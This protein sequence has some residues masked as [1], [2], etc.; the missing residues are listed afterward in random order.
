MAALS[1]AFCLLFPALI[2]ILY[3][4][5]RWRVV[6]PAI[7]VEGLGPVEGIRRSW[8][9]TLNYWWRTLGLVALLGV[10]SYVIS[11][12][13]TTVIVFILLYATPTNPVL[14]SA[15]SGAVGTATSLLFLPLELIAITLYY[16]DLRV[17][18]EGF[19]LDAAMRQAYQYGQ[20]GYG[21][22]YPQQ[23][24]APQG[25]GPASGY[26]AYGQP[27]QDQ[28]GQYQYPQGQPQPNPAY[29]PVPGY[30]QQGQ[31]T[32]YPSGYPP[33]QGQQY[34]P[35]YPAQYGYGPA[36]TP[37]PQE[38]VNLG[39]SIQPPQVAPGP[40]TPAS[41]PATEDLAQSASDSGDNTP[42]GNDPLG[43]Y[44]SEEQAQPAEEPRQ[45]GGEESGTIPEK[46]EPEV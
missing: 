11:V 6:V 4:Y 38:T 9:L 28:Y 44:P 18:K 31:Q 34:A 15:L 5:I 12:G 41:T 17:R 20:A 36:A 24:Y 23:G 16:F 27:T 37:Q 3:V 26:G 40:L 1:L 33:A 25:Y 8:R 45:S 30:E 35:E 22:G 39:T 43:L 32:P 29:P 21:Y 42:Y 7:V 2:F 10:I 13:P 19:D 14:A 46:R